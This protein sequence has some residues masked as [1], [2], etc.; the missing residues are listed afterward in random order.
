MG[1]C[2]LNHT[3]PHD[4]PAR[5]NLIKT[6]G[7]CLLRNAEGEGLGKTLSIWCSAKTMASSSGEQQTAVRICAVIAPQPRHRWLPFSIWSECLFRLRLIK[8]QVLLIPTPRGSL[9]NMRLLLN[10][11]TDLLTEGFSDVLSGVR[12]KVHSSKKKKPS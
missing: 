5:C 12:C 6:E 2:D 3:T 9:K 8:S 10:S 4:C 7:R 1:T 11:K